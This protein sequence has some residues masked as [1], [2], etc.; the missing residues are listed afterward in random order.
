MIALSGTSGHKS[1]G[2]CRRSSPE[3]SEVVL[4]CE[5]CGRARSPGDDRKLHVKADGALNKGCGQMLLQVPVPL[6]FVFMSPFLVS[7]CALD[8]CTS[9]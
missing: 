6:T 5:P 1:E 7:C 3:F 4:A 2:E 8:H 9:D